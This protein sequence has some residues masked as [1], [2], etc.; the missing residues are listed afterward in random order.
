MAA[1]HVRVARA[2]QWHGPESA[3]N[4][5][6][7]DSLDT[8]SIYA[9]AELGRQYRKAKAFLR[10]AANE[11]LFLTRVQIEYAPPLPWRLCAWQPST[12]NL[13]VNRQANDFSQIKPEIGLSALPNSQMIPE[14]PP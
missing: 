9:T 3:R 8:I 14:F 1:S 13:S 11:R 2:R 10:L 5:D 12:A 6:G 4:F 7:H